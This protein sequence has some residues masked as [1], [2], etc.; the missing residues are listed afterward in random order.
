MLQWGTRLSCG[1]SFSAYLR[2]S[3]FHN[4]LLRATTPPTNKKLRILYQSGMLLPY[5]I[6][7][8][9]FDW[10]CYKAEFLPT[11]E[12]EQKTRMLAKVASSRKRLPL[13][14]TSL[15][16]MESLSLPQVISMFFLFFIILVYMDI[17]VLARIWIKVVLEQDNQIVL[18]ADLQC[19]E[20]QKKVYD[21]ISRARG[22]FLIWFLLYNGEMH[23]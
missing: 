7:I 22:M 3:L 17:R 19:T 11:K 8:F 9:C 10:L 16:S 6:F 15:A 23:S 18:S 13:P 12:Q 5:M 2:T 20:C 4:Q 1:I 21:V 14:P